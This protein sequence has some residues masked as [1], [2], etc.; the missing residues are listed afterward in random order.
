MNYSECPLQQISA[1][2][3]PHVRYPH[4]HTAGS[5]AKQIRLWRPQRGSVHIADHWNPL[6]LRRFY[7]VVKKVKCV[8]G[9]A[10]LK[11]LQIKKTATQFCCSTW[12]DLSASTGKGNG[13]KTHKTSVISPTAGP[14]TA[15]HRFQQQPPV[16]LIH[17]NFNLSTY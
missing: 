16:H 11:K 17:F 15:Q 2:T 5:C 10:F 1:V 14:V 9:I 8:I 7:D 12:S 13:I 4:K 3:Y 6:T